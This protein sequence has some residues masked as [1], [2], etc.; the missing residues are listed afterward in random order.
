MCYKSIYR[1]IGGVALPIIIQNIIDASVNSADILMLN[2]V[3]QD[4][5]SAVS[6][7]NSLVGIL[8]MFLYGIGTGI[9]M[10]AAQYYGKNDLKTIEKIE[11]IGLRFTLLVAIPGAILCTMTP[12]TLMYIYTSDAT[13]IELGAKY[14]LYIA[15]GLIFWAI[16]AVYMSILRCI[17]KVGTSTVIETAALVI[18]V[19]LNALF[20]F[21]LFGAPKLG[22]IGVAIA[23]SISRFIQLLLC[24]YVSL[25][26]AKV[27][28]TFSTIFQR[29][30]LLEKDFFTM[31]LPAIGNDLVWALAF[32]MYSVI[33][34]HLGN[35][36]VAANSISNVVRNLGTV[37]CYGVG[38]AA[39]IIVG[40]I[41]GSGDIEEGTRAGHTLL[42]LAVV[43]GIIGGFI[44]LLVMP[45]AL[46]H[47][48]LTDTAKDYLKF[49]LLIN[50]YYITGTSVN[51]CLI[52][53]VFRAG[54]DSRF[55][56][57]CDTID[58]WCYAVPLGLLAAFVFKL[59]VKVVYFLL[60]TDEFVKWPWVFKHFYSHKWAKNITRETTD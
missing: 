12:K 60:C 29:H 17:G 16:S 34:G 59:P 25:T 5:I 2:Y 32:S 49:M 44:V 54:G 11:G 19:C 55:G 18:N 43:T 8:F 4:A 30:K 33:L 26:G 28:L 41:L 47:A 14:L 27:K 21:G 37:L 57:I 52:A 35:D 20:I 31:A 51:S 15:P 36:A 7:A 58:M 56:F 38:S 1:K 39:G 48:A 40:Q 42:R 10:L 23:T 3:G 24:V 6:L 22:V 13:L 50:T 46:K 9:A 53:G 45:F